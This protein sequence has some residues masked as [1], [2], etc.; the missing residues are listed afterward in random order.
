VI[1]TLT[2]T[3]TSLLRLVDRMERENHTLTELRDTL[4]PKLISGQLR[5][6]DTAET[7]ARA[8]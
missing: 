7:E 5:I 4:L 2:A 3:A 6:A 1:A 8:M